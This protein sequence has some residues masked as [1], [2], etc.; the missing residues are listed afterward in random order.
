MIRP[1]IPCDDPIR[2]CMERDFPPFE[3]APPQE[4]P[5]RLP[6]DEPAVLELDS[7]VPQDR[8]RRIFLPRRVPHR[9]DGAMPPTTLPRIYL[10]T[11][12]IDPHT[13]GHPPVPQHEIVIERPK[14]MPFVLPDTIPRWIVT[15]GP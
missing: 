7:C 1:I 10:S 14:C 13:H 15:V 12:A 8:P 11:K 4:D 2:V 5:R 6:L 9:P 3:E